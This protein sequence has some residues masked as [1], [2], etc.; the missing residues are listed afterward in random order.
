MARRYGGGQELPPEAQAALRA[1]AVKRVALE[2]AETGRSTWDH[3][4]LGATY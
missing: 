2:F 1:Q 3:R 4:K